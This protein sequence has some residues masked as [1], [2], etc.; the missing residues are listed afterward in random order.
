ML[1]MTAPTLARASALCLTLA[2]IPISGCFYAEGGTLTS[3]DQY[4]YV[5][6]SYAPKT[7]TLRNTSTGEVLWSVDIP[8]GQQLTV[9]F[10]KGR[11]K[12]NDPS[13]PDVLEWRIMAAGKRFGRLSNKMPI[14]MA[15]SRLME[16]TI[17][18]TPELPGAIVATGGP[19]NPGDILEPSMVDE[20]IA[21]PAM[22][23]MP[24]DDAEF[25]Y[26]DDG[27]YE[28]FENDLDDMESPEPDFEDIDEEPLV[29]LIDDDGLR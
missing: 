28:D 14:P 24:A 13:M 19:Q 8:V 10:V 6:R 25:E 22:D 2:L 27:M 7:M 26:D 9:K 11:N 16:M 17:R 18:P 29:P 15:S 21:A 4:T 23:E 12:K 20:S 3:L 5:S 1:R